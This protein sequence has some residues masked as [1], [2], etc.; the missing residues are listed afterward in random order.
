LLRK[1]YGPFTGRYKPELDE[2][3]ELDPIRANLYHSQIGILR[4]CV[5][6]G[7]LDIITEVSTL[8][9]YLFLLHG[10]HLEYF[11]LVFAYLALQ[12]NMRVVFDPTY[13]S[14]DTGTFIKTDWKSMYGDVKEI[15]PA[16]APV[17]CGKEVDLC[18]CVDSDHAGEKFTRRSRNG[19]KCIW[20]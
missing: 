3:P 14:V 5:E 18:L 9:T 7:R 6:M 17:P 16:G 19:I 10:G 20:S 1:A 4:W 11:L 2:S 8:S 13:P 15:I 12:H